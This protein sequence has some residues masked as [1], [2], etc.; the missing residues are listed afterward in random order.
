MKEVR[1]AFVVPAGSKDMMNHSE[2]IQDTYSIL[3]SE[4]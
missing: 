1:V 3:Q 2:E 4:S